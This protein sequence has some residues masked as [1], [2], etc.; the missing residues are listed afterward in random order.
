[1]VCLAGSVLASAALTLVAQIWLDV[2]IDGLWIGGIISVALPIVIAAPCIAVGLKLVEHLAGLRQRLQREVDQRSVAEARLRRLVTED[3]LT[4]LSN[5]RDFLSRARMALAMSRRYRHGV[6][7]LLIDLD[8]FKQVNDRHGH[9]I[10]DE[11]LVRFARVLRHELRATDTAA[12]IGGD[13]FVALLPQTDLQAAA[14]VAERI[15]RAIADD[16]AEPAL[17]VTIGCVVGNG[18]R[19]QLAQL[20]RA[21]D[22]ALYAGKRAGR[23]RVFIAGRSGPTVAGDGPLPASS[24]V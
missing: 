2:P 13:E 19:P 21:A 5:R 22:Q 12:R 17:T 7:I 20:L 9:Q 24:V 1:V 23:N 8:G 16:D 18:S 3:E 14:M 11:A 6:G 15:R 4:G 10:G